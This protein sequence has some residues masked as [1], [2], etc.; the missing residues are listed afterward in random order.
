MTP[1]ATMWSPLTQSTTLTPP[2]DPNLLRETSSDTGIRRILR[3]VTTAFSP[4]G[5]PHA[6]KRGGLEASPPAAFVFGRLPQMPAGALLGGLPRRWR[7]R[8]R[9]SGPQLPVKS[10]HRYHSCQKR[11][12]RKAQEARES[13]PEY[14]RTSPVGSLLPG[15]RGPV[16]VPDG[17][18]PRGAMGRH[19]ST[20]SA[21]AV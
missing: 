5:G 16:A 12:R 14:V 3:W 6:Y 19:R 1:P 4:P 10:P 17:G 21:D 8:R 11:G 9:G 7:A 20:D 18:P 2:L 15:A 13:G